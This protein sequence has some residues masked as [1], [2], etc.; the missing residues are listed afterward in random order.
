[1]ENKKVQEAD[2]ND[3]DEYLG[4]IWGWKLSFISLGIIVAMLL[5][6]GIR[7]FTMD[8]PTIPA[9]Q[10]TTI[11]QDSLPGDTIPKD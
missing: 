3:K 9:N 8:K 6:M 4:N 1:M 11:G 2:E 7:Y 10:Q 5:L